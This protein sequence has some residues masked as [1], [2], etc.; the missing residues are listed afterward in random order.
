M[1]VALLYSGMPRF[2]IEKHQNHLDYLF[3]NKINPDVY[4]SFW[5]LWGYNPNGWGYDI[6]HNNSQLLTDNDK[7][8]IVDT[9]V[10]KNYEF[11]NFETTSLELEEII[12]HK[13]S[14]ASSKKYD[15]NGNPRSYVFQFY[16][17]SRTIKL[18]KEEYD[19]IVRIR[20]D[21]HFEHYVIDYKND[22]LIHIYAGYCYPDMND[23]FAY[24]SQSVMK[25]YFDVFDNITSIDLMHP[26]SILHEHLTMNSI[27]IQKDI[28]CHYILQR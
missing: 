25:T 28:D 24:G 12:Q 15:W 27:T 1:K 2:I 4:F 8:N 3:N 22:N 7:Q 20:S 11:T 17:L 9:L 19:I 6:N 13:I 14:Q 23:Q 5:N 16:S 18:L 10:P 21:L 26:E